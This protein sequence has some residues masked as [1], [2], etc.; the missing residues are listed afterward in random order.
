M[1]QDHGVLGVIESKTFYVHNI[2][3][4]YNNQDRLRRLLASPVIDIE[5]INYIY[6]CLANGK[7]LI[8]AH[9]L[10]HQHEVE[11]VYSQRS[12]HPTVC[13]IGSIHS[14]IVSVSHLF[15]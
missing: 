9:D 3:L 11:S 8:F 7:E 2:A 4:A 14:P 10:Q 5:G 15:M 6:G 1:R 13:S 12:K